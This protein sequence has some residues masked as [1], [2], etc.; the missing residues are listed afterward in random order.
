MNALV[1]AFY[2][3]M[4]V[5]ATFQ[6]C[7]CQ[8][9]ESLLSTAVTMRGVEQTICGKI[10]CSNQRSKSEQLSNYPHMIY[11]FLELRKLV[12]MAIWLKYL[13]FMTIE[14]RN[15]YLLWIF[16]PVTKYFLQDKGWCWELHSQSALTGFELSTSAGWYQN[17]NSSIFPADTRISKYWTSTLNLIVLL[18]KRMFMRRRGAILHWCDVCDNQ[19]NNSKYSSC[20]VT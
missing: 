15:F 8:N 10:Q 18:R 5:A 1:A 13:C 4:A 19:T 2:T 3:E 9:W 6:N 11:D 7:P 20:K 14:Y 16:C 17:Q 12:S